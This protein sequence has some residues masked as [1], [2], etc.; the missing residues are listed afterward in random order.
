MFF[1]K[2]YYTKHLEYFTSAF[3]IICMYDTYPNYT[4]TYTE[5][6]TWNKLDKDMQS[7]HL[8]IWDELSSNVTFLKSR[9]ICLWVSL[10]DIVDC[11]VW[12]CSRLLACKTYSAVIYNLVTKLASL[13][14]PSRYIQLG[15]G[16]WNRS[17]NKKL[18]HKKVDSVPML[19]FFFS[20]KSDV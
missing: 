11:P 20:T 15:H 17:S 10:T 14:L 5:D 7:L 9:S 19:L 12:Y 18:W 1:I 3:F 2:E 8:F 6:V 13:I 16:V 4:H